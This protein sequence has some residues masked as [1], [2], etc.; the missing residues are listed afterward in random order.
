MKA[1]IEIFLS[2]REILGQSKNNKEW[3]GAANPFN[4]HAAWREREA[5]P[6]AVCRA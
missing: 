5:G 6:G 4:M 1:D 2:L 3:G